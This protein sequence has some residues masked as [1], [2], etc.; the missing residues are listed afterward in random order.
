MSVSD[1]GCFPGLG[2]LCRA[3]CVWPLLVGVPAL[4]EARE[5]QGAG[6]RGC[7]GRTWAGRAAC[8]FLMSSLT[9]RGGHLCCWPYTKQASRG[10]NRSNPHLTLEGWCLIR[11]KLL[12]QVSQEHRLVEIAL[13]DALWVSSVADLA[14]VL[15]IKGVKLTARSLSFAM[16]DSKGSSL[17]N[18]HLFLWKEED[19]YTDIEGWD[20]LVSLSSFHSPNSVPSA[21]LHGHTDSLPQF[22]L[23]YR[24]LML[25]GML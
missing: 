13:A 2:F 3:L 6:A 10:E 21:V 14:G 8:L 20:D 19:S 12:G 18:H 25:S 17:P 23:Y 16:S 24:V 11:L 1:S 7:V 5:W 22:P 15:V 9:Q 4:L